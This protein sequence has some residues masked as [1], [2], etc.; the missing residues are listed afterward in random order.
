MNSLGSRFRG[1]DEPE[2]DP[3]LRRDDD[4]AGARV[5]R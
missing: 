3:G 2:L 4:V 5:P 1:N